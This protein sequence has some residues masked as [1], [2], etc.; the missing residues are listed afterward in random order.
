LHISTFLAIGKK[1]MTASQK[2]GPPESKGPHGL[3][4]VG[5]LVSIVCLVVAILIVFWVLGFGKRSAYEISAKHDL[6]KFVEAEEAYFRE[7][8]QYKGSVHSTIAN[9]TGKPSTLS[10]EGFTPSEGV[11]VTIIS[12][13]P[14]IAVSEHNKAAAVFEYNFEVGVMNKK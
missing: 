5:L 11:S 1:M 2:S 6:T 14:F 12:D 3:T 8:G 7:T 4:V 10:L 13:D 9:D